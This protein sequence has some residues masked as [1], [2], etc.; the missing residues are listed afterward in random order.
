[1]IVSVIVCVSVEVGVGVLVTLVVGVLVTVLVGIGEFT[2]LFCFASSIFLWI[3]SI[4]KNCG[5]VSSGIP[6]RFKHGLSLVHA[7]FVGEYPPYTG[8]PDT[9]PVN[10]ISIIYGPVY[11]VR[12]SISKTN[13]QVPTY[14]GMIWFTTPIGNW[15]I[16]PDSSIYSARP[17][18]IPI[19][20]VTAVKLQT[21]K[22]LQ[23]TYEIGTVS[24]G[25]DVLVIVLVGVKVGVIEDVKVFVGVW[26]GVWVG[27]SVGD[28]VGVCVGVSED[29]CVGV[30]VG[31]SIASDNSS[32]KSSVS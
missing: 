25:V 16:I 5:S 1:M 29:V 17:S 22:I 21:I 2:N 20:K 8:L 10:G 23:E 24:V 30:C 15:L 31:H 14:P 32:H 3:S 19:E 26:V 6:S 13:A 12:K 28:T 7:K 9:P 18:S 11:G 4:L 27:V